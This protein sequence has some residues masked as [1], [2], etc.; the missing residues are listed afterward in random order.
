MTIDILHSSLLIPRFDDCCIEF[1][2]PCLKC[3]G[4]AVL[5]EAV[6]GSGCAHHQPCNGHGVGELDFERTQM[7]HLQSY[8]NHVLEGGGALVCAL[9]FGY[10]RDNTLLL[11][12]LEAVTDLDF[13][14]EP[15]TAST[16]TTAPTAKTLTYNGEEQALVTAGAASPGAMVYSV[17]SGSCRK[18]CQISYTGLSGA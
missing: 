18:I 15:T 3:Y 9:H 8:F 14:I 10:G 7:F 5:E 11:H 2:E 16:V 1:G 13:T 17:E 6:C 12:A 4:T